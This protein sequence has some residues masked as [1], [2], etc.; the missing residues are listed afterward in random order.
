MQQ[1]LQGPLLF[2][3]S[4]SGA[5]ALLSRI[6]A[7]SEWRFCVSFFAVSDPPCPSVLPS[8]LLNSSGALS[9]ARRDGG[10]DARKIAQLASCVRRAGERREEKEGGRLLVP[11]A[12]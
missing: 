1:S 6:I 2:C 4:V 11:I 8:E 10:G 5:A 7:S 12:S 3:R 9:L